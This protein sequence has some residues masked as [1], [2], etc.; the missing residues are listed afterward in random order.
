MVPPSSTSSSPSDLLPCAAPTL[1]GSFLDA[2]PGHYIRRLQQIAVALFMEETA[3]WGVT[4]V[5]FATLM[6]AHEY[7]GLD[8]RSLAALIRFD[9]STIG[10]VID[11]L[12]K[13]GLILRNAAAHDRRLRLLTVTPEGQALLDQVLPRVRTVQQRILAPLPA[14][15]QAQ[16]LALIKRVVD[17]HGEALPPARDAD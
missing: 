12:E 4:P 9:T 15:D 1:A 13:R 5:Q 14:A 10:G 7:P 8:Q 6:A 3:D 2:Q 17:A 11:R 16:L